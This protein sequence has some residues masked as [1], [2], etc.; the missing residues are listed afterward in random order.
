MECWIKVCSLCG[1][2]EVSTETVLFSCFLVLAVILI[3]NVTKQIANNINLLNLK[4]I[5]LSSVLVSHMLFNLY[6]H[7]LMDYENK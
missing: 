2:I 4:A 1:Y 3:S 6:Y 5:E 7:L